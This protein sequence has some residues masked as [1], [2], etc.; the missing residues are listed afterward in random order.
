MFGGFG[1]KIAKHRKPARPFTARPAAAG[2]HAR[3][4]GIVD[5][6]DRV[7]VS[8]IEIQRFEEGA[9]TA[10]S[11]QE[12][13][14]EEKAAP[15]LV[16]VLQRGQAGMREMNVREAIVTVAP[17]F[18]GASDIAKYRGRHGFA[19]GGGQQRQHA[20]LLPIEACEP[21]RS[22]SRDQHGAGTQH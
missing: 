3:L 8:R 15:R 13:F 9:G 7:D 18:R 5:F 2:R 20:R 14:G 1:R 4:C 10:T 19:V 6:L 21:A 12:S 16:S 17:S 22:V 11:L